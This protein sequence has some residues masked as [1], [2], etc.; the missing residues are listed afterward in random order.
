M[1]YYR[2]LKAH[3]DGDVV[4]H[5][6]TDAILGTIG[7]G[8]IGLH[9]PPSD[10]QWKDKDSSFFLRAAIEMLKDKGGTINNIDI[11]I[12]CEEPKLIPLR[13]QM[14]AHIASL[15]NL[16]DPQVN[17][18]ATTTEKLGFTGRREGIACQAIVCAKYQK[19]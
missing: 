3:S 12:I 14:K 13:D 1:P 19:T 15:M 5:A 10:P 9:F 8:D 6:L 4:L 11:T 18:K 17:L 16:S 2:N 7:E